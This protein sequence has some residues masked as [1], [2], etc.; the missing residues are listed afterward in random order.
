MPAQPQPNKDEWRL[1][2]LMQQPCPYC[3]GIEIAHRLRR[4]T[5]IGQNTGI[6]VD[7]HRTCRCELYKRYW[8]NWEQAIDA[9]Y[10]DVRFAT[11]APSDDPEIRA[12]LATQARII[13]FVKAHPDDSHLLYG[14]SRCGKS[15]ISA[16][17]HDYHLRRWAMASYRDSNRSRSPVLRANVT[18]LLAQHHA[19]TTSRADEN[20][21]TP[22][23]D[24][25]IA[26]IRAVIE[27]GDKP[28]LILDE[29][30]KLGGQPT[31]F[32]IETLL[33]LIDAVN[34]ER[35]AVIATSNHA[36][37]WFPATWG[38]ELGEPIVLRIMGGAAAH[39][40]RFV[41]DRTSQ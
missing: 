6:E 18:R 13:D 23:P 10:R 36:P 30:D 24:I 21:N 37:E 14:D 31:P 9:R 20:A 12:S 4:C 16:A 11:L 26:R 25:D 22:R 17:L 32:R 3:K 19:W 41:A 34:N 7:G 5:Y 33:S 29:L 27:Q 2:G 15:H 35:G 38:K 39:K 8:T 40:V 1:I 28:V